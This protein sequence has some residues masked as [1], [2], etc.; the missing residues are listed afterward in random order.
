M[1]EEWEN[2]SKIEE[3]RRT[4]IEGKSKRECKKREEKKIIER[5]KRRE[6]NF[7]NFGLKNIVTL[8]VSVVPS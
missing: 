2:R 6:A 1:E 3:R 5:E 7:H 4:K 8:D